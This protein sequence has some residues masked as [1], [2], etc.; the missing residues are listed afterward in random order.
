MSGPHEYATIR[1]F[2]G[3]F[4]G[5]T[6]ADITQH[7]QDEWEEGTSYVMVQFTDGTFIQFSD[8]ADFGY[9]PVEAVE[10]SAS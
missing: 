9:G 4:I 6:I 3:Q 8:V 10:D 5:K 2:L 1:D 7:D